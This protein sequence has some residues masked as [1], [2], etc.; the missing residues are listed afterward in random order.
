M[1]ENDRQNEKLI[2]YS[3]VISFGVCPNCNV[4]YKLRN[5]NI[6]KDGIHRCKNCG[7]EVPLIKKPPSVSSF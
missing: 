5:S 7:T 3:S 1:P 6:P 2:E 4:I